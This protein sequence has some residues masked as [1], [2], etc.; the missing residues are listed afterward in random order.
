MIL[1]T[2]SLPSGLTGADLSI[3]AAS[4]SYLSDITTIKDRSM[5]VTFL[6]ATYLLSMPIG[7]ALGKTKTVEAALH[8][9][10]I[11]I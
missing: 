3:F 7:V 1:W 9:K 5:R 2:A 4:F 10:N 11:Y 6:D 8:N